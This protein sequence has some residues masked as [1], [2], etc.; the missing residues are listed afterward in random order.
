M[1]PS[2]YVLVIILASPFLL[3]ADDNLNKDIND[4]LVSIDSTN[5]VQRQEKID[6]EAAQLVKKYNSNLAGP[7]KTLATERDNVKRKFGLAAL[8]KLGVCDPVKQTFLDLLKNSDFQVRND[9]VCA[10]PKI[11]K[12]F[13]REVVVEAINTTTNQN[14]KM[15]IIPLLGVI[16]DSN[17]LVILKGIE[18]DD[19]E[20][21]DLKRVAH[22]AREY[23]EYRL[24]LPTEE[25]QR[26]W[27]DQAYIYWSVFK[28]AE[29]RPYIIDAGKYSASAMLMAQRGYKFS[30]SF[31]KYHLNQK[32]PLAVAIISEQNEKDAIGDLKASL[33]ADGNDVRLFK[34][35]CRKVLKNIEQQEPNGPRDPNAT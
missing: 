9:A 25:Q 23:L 7:M 6:V 15:S 11:D 16:G 17:T 35:M 1:K 5:F 13:A 27:A 2:I 24:K 26:S 14:V 4:S 29:G 12:D 10:L 30:L 31:L 20:N 22:Q 8:V 33:N 3:L 19:S 21:A 18:K 32:D 28:E 34:E